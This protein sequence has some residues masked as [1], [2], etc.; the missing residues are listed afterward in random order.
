MNGGFP[1]VC[2]VDVPD[3]E[4]GFARRCQDRSEARTCPES[5]ELTS[6]CRSSWAGRPRQGGLGQCCPHKPQQVRFEELSHG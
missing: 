3:I 2:V 4:D 5:R 6:G 1:W